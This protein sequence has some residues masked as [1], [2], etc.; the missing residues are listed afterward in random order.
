MYVC[1]QGP[2][3]QKLPEAIVFLCFAHA[4]HVGVQGHNSAHMGLWRQA[5]LLLSAFH[6][7]IALG[8]RLNG[9]S[10]LVETTTSA[11]PAVQAGLSR[12]RDGTASWSTLLAPPVYAEPNEFS[13]GSSGHGRSLLHGCHGKNRGAPAGSNVEKCASANL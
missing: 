10:A 11:S 7:S 1:C 13:H 5:V 6:W 12:A 3:A 2:S 8:I 4:M 9:E